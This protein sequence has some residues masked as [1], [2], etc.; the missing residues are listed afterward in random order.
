MGIKLFIFLVE[1]TGEKYVLTIVMLRCEN[2][3]ANAIGYDKK[4]SG[5]QERTLRWG[6]GSWRGTEDM[7]L[8][9]SRCH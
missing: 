3:C 5:K 6:H 2:T 4:G 1:N 8:G 7:E 9:V